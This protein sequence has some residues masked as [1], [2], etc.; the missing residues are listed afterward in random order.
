[1][2]AHNTLIGLVLFLIGWTNPSLASQEL[3]KEWSKTYAVDADATLSV[4]NKFGD[5]VLT[6]WDQNTIEVKVTIT[7][8]DGS[9]KSAQKTLDAISIQDKSSKSRV[10]LK[11]DMDSKGNSGNRELSIDYEIK[12]P[13]SLHLELK[14]AFGGISVPNIQGSVALDVSY[15]SFKAGVLSAKENALIFNFSNG[16]IEQFGGGSITFNYGTL[17]IDDCK[18]SVIKSSFS[19][20]N[21]DA[22]TD[23]TLD[24]QYDKVSIDQAGTLKVEAAFTA[25]DIDHVNTLIDAKIQYSGFEVDHIDAGFKSIKIDSEMGSVELNIASDAS[26]NF[27]A[28]AFM[29]D[30]SL[31]S[32]AVVEKRIEKMHVKDLIGHLG[33]KPGERMVE[34]EVHN[35]SIDIH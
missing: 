4:N 6:T 26:Y 23:L 25:F 12:A 19:T 1:M 5:I 20:I 11:T 18:T 35:A 31:P 14:N 17:D 3:T 2:K 24:S 27:R 28:A 9:E 10:E 16:I 32:K 15:G 7:V 30:V 22:V 29:G 8:E 33:D 21:L 13:A 34:V